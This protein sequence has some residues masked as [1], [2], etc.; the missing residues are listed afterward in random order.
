[1]RKLRNSELNRVSTEEFKAIVKLP[2]IVVLDDVRSMHN[3]GSVFRTSDGFKVEK[4]VL[5]GIT[6]TPPQ[7][8][9]EKTALGSTESVEWCHRD[10]L[11]SFVL[12]S[13]KEGYRSIA[14]EHTSKSIAL[15]EYVMSQQKVVLVFGNEI[16]GVSQE[17]LE[18]CDEILEIPQFGTKHSFNIAVSA[19][20]GIWEFAKTFIN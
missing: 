9:I 15:T 2:I 6:P 7:P 5:G 3:V 14:F 19:G 10:D 8:E 1:M 16:K 17:V 18:V 13:K 20:I 11:V 12:E 4:I